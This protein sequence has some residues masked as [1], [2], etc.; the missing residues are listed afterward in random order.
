MQRLTSDA[1]TAFLADPEIND[2]VHPS[3]VVLRMTRSHSF[4]RK[5][6]AHPK[7]KIESSTYHLIIVDE[8]QDADSDVVRKSIH[9][10][11]TAVGGSIV[12]VGTPAAHR[13]DFYEALQRN[14]HGGRSHGKKNYF[15]F[16]WKHAARANP[17]YEQSIQKEK[18][19]LGEDSDEFQMSY[20]LKWL[21][22]RGMFIT[23]EQFDF[24]GDKRMDPHPHHTATPIVIGIDLAR[25]HD[26]TICTAIWVDWDH[27]DEFGLYRHRVLDWLELHGEEWESQYEQICQFASQYNV[28]KIG[29][30]AQGMG[31]PVAE[32]LQ[33]LL[34]RTEVVALKMDPIDQSARWTHLIQLMQ[35]ELVGWPASGNTR[36]TRRY[37]RF[38]QQMCDAEKEY[39]GKY[40]YVHAPD[41]ER[42]AHD[43]YVD[44]LA[45]GCAL[46]MEFDQDLNVEVWNSN[47]FLERGVGA[48][49]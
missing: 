24:L 3:G 16:D 37:K 27:P 28:F 9:P 13:S 20:N 23:E 21:L 49:R 22:D 5:Q 26:S 2:E 32:H 40:L 12:K 4:C 25:R 46:T 1:A 45:L 43:D 10:M 44:S 19:R 18:D 38:R 31:G 15:A 6:T 29:V 34:P 47:P 8:A 14:K 48:M 42:N 33:V 36:R 39:K 35:R 41:N 17:Y 30:D 11:T 7:A